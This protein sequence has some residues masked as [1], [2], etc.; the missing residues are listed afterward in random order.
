M[1]NPYTE[2]VTCSV[3]GGEGVARPLDAAQQWR[4]AEFAHRDPAACRDRLARQRRGLEVEL[5]EETE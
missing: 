4:G 3:C 2:T 1:M 5:R